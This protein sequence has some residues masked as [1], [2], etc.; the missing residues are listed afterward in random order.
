MSLFPPVVLL[1]PRVTPDSVTV[2]RECVRRG[3]EVQRLSS[4]RIPSEFKEQ[5]KRFIVYAE[6]LFAE[7]VADQ[8][9]CVL[10]EPPPDWLEK[11]PER[12]RKRRVQ[13]STLGRT[14]GLGGPLFV[15]P[16]EGKSFEAKVYR[17]PA[18]L[19]EIGTFDESLPVLC[20]EPVTWELEVRCFVRDRK[21]ASLSPYWRRGELAQSA[22]GSWP[23]LPGEA[24][25]ALAF[26]ESLLADSEVMLPPAFVLD[27]GITREVGWAV[28]EGNPCWGAGLYGCDV[29]A[30]LDSLAESMVPLASATEDLMSWTSP[31][32]QER[33][34]QINPSIPAPSARSTTA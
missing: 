13:V 12:Y 3:W 24:E 29:A 23:F 28:V 11:L 32:V 7:A 5:P 18:D 14:R 27:V 26:A 16:A 33:L 20:S 15:K 25:E 1:A 34:R 9:D 19:P 4:W 30:V 21:L 2:W 10:V 8:L 6:P 31:R 17:S 22:D